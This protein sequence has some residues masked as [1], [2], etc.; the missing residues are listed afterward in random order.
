MADIGVSQKSAAKPTWIW[1]LLAVLAVGAL[2]WWLSVQTSEYE[3]QVVLDDPGAA[4]VDDGQSAGPAGEAVE[5]PAVAAAPDGFAGRTV[6]L[7]NVQVAATLGP[8]AFW[9]DVPG[10]NPFLVVLD[11]D[12]Q[13]MPEFAAG[14]RLSLTGLVE[15]VDEAVLDSWIQSGAMP[16]SRR[17]E[18]AFAT[19]YMRA[20]RARLAA[21]AAAE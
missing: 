13:R 6:A 15:T 19:H 16:E 21:P 10:A 3:A 17:E 14:E 4:E 1:I 7:E 9:A 20:Q 2:M 12:M 18:A 5:L 8:R 11:D